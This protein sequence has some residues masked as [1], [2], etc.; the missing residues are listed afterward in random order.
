[1]SLLI[2]AVFWQMGKFPDLVKVFSEAVADS[3]AKTNQDKIN[4]ASSKANDAYQTYLLGL[5][6]TA[7]LYST[8]IATAASFDTV[9]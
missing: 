1:M 2:L 6:G 9:L 5:A 8:Q 7:F 4:E 3:K